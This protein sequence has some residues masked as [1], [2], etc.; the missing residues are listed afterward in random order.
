MKTSLNRFQMGLHATVDIL[1]CEHASLKEIA[2][3]GVID[4][5]TLFQM[6]DLRGLN[7]SGQDLTGMNFFGADLRG[8]L[9][10]KISFDEG[11]FNGAKIDKEYEGFVD[12]YDTYVSDLY[13]DL[14]SGIYIFVKFR[15]NS[16]DKIVS[17]MNVSFS[18]FARSS[19]I[20]TAT[21]RNARSSLTVSLETAFY[22]CR[23]IY[24]HY[25]KIR[26]KNDFGI[27][28]HQ[29]ICELYHNK[30]NRGNVKLARSDARM[31]K[32][33]FDTLRQ[34]NIFTNAINADGS[35]YYQSSP[36]VVC[37]YLEIYSLHH[38]IPQS[39]LPHREQPESFDQVQPRL[40]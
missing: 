18:E 19:H 6:A 27:Y 31:V 5:V 7:L 10:E 40:I 33:G 4:V 36:D 39:M 26:N 20:S 17:K 2:R 32:V 13:A 14:F 25:N 29:P 11:A 15:P 9:L 16:L 37:W 38:L 30:G 12:E 21:L 24:S 1:A 28:I 8:T 23:T 35:T 22:I 3:Q 34:R